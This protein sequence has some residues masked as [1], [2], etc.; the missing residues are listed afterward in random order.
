MRWPIGRGSD[1]ADAHRLLAW[2]SRR[3]LIAMRFDKLSMRSNNSRRTG[4]YN[5]VHP[6]RW[7]CASGALQGN[8]FPNHRRAAMVAATDFLFRNSSSGL[9]W[10]TGDCGERR[11]VR[12]YNRHMIISGGL[13]RR[14][15]RRP[16]HSRER[17]LGPLWHQPEQQGALPL[18]SL[19]PA[20]ANRQR[21]TF[22]CK[23]AQAS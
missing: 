16:G 1:A 8:H 12:G 17:G 19:A 23:P 10:R 5:F 7:R 13:E 9:D 22:A 6:R 2:R 11:M 14:P 3:T 15:D 18:G 4:H 21:H 20:G